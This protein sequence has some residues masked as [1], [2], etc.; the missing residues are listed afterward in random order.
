MHGA[1]FC[2]RKRGLQPSGSCSVRG[3]TPVTLFPLPETGEDEG[4]GEG[5]GDEEK[6]EPCMTA[7]RG[8]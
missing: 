4:G 6:I 3:P 1:V 7:A 2:L 8:A 5:K